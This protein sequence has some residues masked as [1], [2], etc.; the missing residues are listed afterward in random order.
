[1]SESVTWIEVTDTAV[2]I[3]LSGIIVAISGYFLTKRNQK[4]DFNKEYFRRRQDVVE[5]VSASFAS[6]HAF[7]FKVCIDYMTLV[8]LLHA[9]LEATESDREKFY[10]Y[11]REI[12]EK[13]HEMHILEGK[14]LVAGANEATQIL[15]QYRLHA[16]EVNGMIKLQLPA[17]KKS[18]VEAI[19]NELFGRKDRF[20]KELAEAFKTI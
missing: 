4:H 9:G 8:E 10:N 12:G 18:E 19:T 3:G 1:M 13:L 7:F 11:I 16:T 5:S 17:M 15:Q 6:I 20:Y 2:K 14:L